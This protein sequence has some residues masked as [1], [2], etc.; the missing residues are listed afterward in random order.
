M[1]F[2]FTRENMTGKMTTA[3]SFMRISKKLCWISVTVIFLEYC[4]FGSA[5]W[6]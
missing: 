4:V 5:E 6:Q 2:L 3:V 1:S